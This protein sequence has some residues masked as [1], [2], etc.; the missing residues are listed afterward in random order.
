MYIHDLSSG[1]RLASL[2]LYIGSIIG[3]SGRKKDTEVYL[4]SFF[5]APILAHIV[6]FS[7]LL[8]L[9]SDD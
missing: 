2:P 6:V 8:L 5:P 3:F 9:T 1:K 7:W 4:L